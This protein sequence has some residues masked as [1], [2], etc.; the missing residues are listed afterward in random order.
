MDEQEMMDITPTTNF[1][2]SL[3]GEDVNYVVVVAEAVRRNSFDAAAQTINVIV[4]RM[5]LRSRMMGLV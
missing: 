5:R 4:I 1:L 2:R 3:R